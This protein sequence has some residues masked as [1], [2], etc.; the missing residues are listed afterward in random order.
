MARP[1]SEVSVSLRQM[2][3]LKNGDRF[4]VDAP[5]NQITA[6]SAKHRIKVKTENVIIT[7]P[8][9]FAQRKLVEVTII[10]ESIKD[11]PE[12]NAEPI[13]KALYRELPNTRGGMAI[14]VLLKQY[15]EQ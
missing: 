10:E 6:Y 14:K 12:P 5:Q 11:I 7:Y 9:T 13:W 3:Y 4:L 15:Y 1:D 2:L 8:K